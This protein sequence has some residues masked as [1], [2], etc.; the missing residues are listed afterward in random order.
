[1]PFKTLP[2]ISRTSF[3][4]LRVPAAKRVLRY[5]MSVVP[6]Y[7]ER[8]QTFYKSTCGIMKRRRIMLYLCACADN[9]GHV[10]LSK[11]PIKLDK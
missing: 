10:I 2:F 11:S 5:D 8:T 7:E 4:V 1:M 3:P 6:K 9:D